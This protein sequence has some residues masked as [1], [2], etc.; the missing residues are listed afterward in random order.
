[1]EFSTNTHKCGMIKFHAK[2]VEEIYETVRD[3]HEKVLILDEQGSSMLM[4][5]FEGDWLRS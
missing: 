4:N 3:I 1:M 5:R 2:T